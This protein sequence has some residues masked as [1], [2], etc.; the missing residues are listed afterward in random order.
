MNAYS[1]K[2]DKLEREFSTSAI[3]GLKRTQVDANRRRF[4][5]NELEK[6]KK[7]SVFKRLIEALSEPTL[8]ILEFA[9]V[10]TV[11]VNVGKLIKTGLCDIYECIGILAAILISACLT[12]FMD[13]KSFRNF[14]VCIR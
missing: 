11:G 14:R 7:K 1:V 9:W 4:G 5:K 10:I 3:Y 13:R 12:V 8:I 2:T 6:K